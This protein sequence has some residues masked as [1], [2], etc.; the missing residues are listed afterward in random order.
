MLHFQNSNMLKNNF[1]CNI[2]NA[3]KLILFKVF[4]C[5]LVF[6]KEIISQGILKRYLIT[7]LI[8]FNQFILNKKFQNKIF[9][10]TK[11]ITCIHN[12]VF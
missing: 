3:Y 11:M 2:S 1:N 8:Y 7:F 10:E 6:F 5:C 4:M 12:H 9:F